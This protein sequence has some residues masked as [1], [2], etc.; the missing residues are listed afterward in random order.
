M[1]IVVVGAGVVGFHLAEELS[2]EGHDISVVDS[3]PELIRK[4]NEKMDVL[5][6]AGDASLPS[7]LEK[8]GSV[9]AD[10][11][12][13]VTDRDTTNV[14]VSIIA[15]NMGA[16]KCLVRVRNAEFAGRSKYLTTEDI[17]ADLIINTIDITAERIERLV[18]NPGATDV[19]EFADGD[20][21]LWGFIVA[22]D[23]PM[24]GMKLRDLREQYGSIEALI[25]AIYRDDGSI[26]IPR[27][28]DALLA[29]DNIYVFIRRKATGAFRRLVH[30]AEERAQKVVISGATPL[31][32]EVARRLE[33][34]VRKLVLV[35]D[36]RE[37]AE[38]ASEQLSR[39]SILC[40]DVSD[41]NFAQEYSLENPDFFLALTRDD[42]TNLMH[43]LLAKR[44][45]GAKRSGVLA[46]QPHYL[47]V[48]KQLGADI[49]VNPRI[50]TVNEILTRIRRGRILHVT[51]IGETGAEAREYVATKGCPIVGKPLKEVGM[52]R[53]AIMSAII[54]QDAFEIPGG[55][56]IVEPGDQ[57]VILALPEAEG[58]VDKLFSKRKLFQR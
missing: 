1:R 44:K 25:V 35:D 29:G 41:P 55:A 8:A 49:V 3:S 15:R 38:A 18:R 53:G 2:G 12:V 21:F 52:P 10:L 46:Q 42:Q 48:L 4:I 56:S 40:G 17:G 27:G 14:L 51:R 16:K 9:D 57:V 58:K 31:G 39:T 23:S 26:V 28:E 7:V 34:R 22:D 30:P 19:S 5:A 13:A 6:V 20:L 45:E 36:K 47:E 32:I 43:G 50:Q 37:R 24:V 33:G 54:R 11:V